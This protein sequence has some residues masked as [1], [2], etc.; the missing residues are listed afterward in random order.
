[1]IRGCL[2][3]VT[4]GGI[5][6]SVVILTGGVTLG[7][8]AISL[9]PFRFVGGM[10]AALGGLV[11]FLN[12][13]LGI[14]G[15]VAATSSIIAENATPKLPVLGG[16]F[17]GYD[18]LLLFLLALAAIQS[19][20]SGRAGGRRTP[21]DLPLIL[22][23]GSGILS[24]SQ[25]NSNPAIDLS[26]ALQ[27]FRR[28]TY[29]LI[30]FPV[31]ILLAGRRGATTL[32]RGL[33]AISVLVSLAMILQAAVGSR[34]E[35]IPGE[36]AVGDGI[37]AVK[38]SSI[39]LVFVMFVAVVSMSVLERREGLDRLR[40][41]VAGLLGLGLLLTHGRNLW[42]AAVAALALLLW[43]LGPGRRGRILLVLALAVG[44][45]L[46]LVPPLAGLSER[47]GAYLDSITDTAASIFTGE[48]N[49]LPLR[50]KEFD[51]AVQRIAENPLWGIGLGAAYRP[52]LWGA[53]EGTDTHNG[54]LW[55]QLKLGSVGLVSFLWFSVLCLARGFRHWKAMPDP[56]LRASL[57]GL[58]LAY[59]GL[60]ASS[61]LTN[62]FAGDLVGPTVLGT[63]A[64]VNENIIRTGQSPDP[65]T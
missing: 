16:S 51:Y 63:I 29:Y 5:Y 46:I 53:D 41:A 8:L 1:M 6:R 30:Y 55:I 42:G 25:A 10:L 31:T 2:T 52:P 3:T 28:I 56:F 39:Q 23:I 9:D 17:R 27:E 26:T 33:I 22:F 47:S 11:S 34:Y 61:L 21:L 32:V 4:S 7:W 50:M 12:P 57:I 18:L 62:R 40:L 49:T 59:L 19:L 24:L 38:T 64:G 15:V 45:V 44:A 60:M 13:A 43:L 35:I 58:T 54:Y 65:E 36:T 14:L 37:G 48:Q 20:H